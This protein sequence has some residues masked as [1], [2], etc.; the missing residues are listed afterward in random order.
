MKILQVPRE[1]FVYSPTALRT[2]I[3]WSYSTTLSVHMLLWCHFHFSSGFWLGGLVLVYE[4]L[5][6]ISPPLGLM[7]VWRCLHVW[8]DVDTVNASDLIFLFCFCLGWRYT[9]RTGINYFNYWIIILCVCV[10][11]KELERNLELSA[12]SFQRQLAAEK[13]RTLSAQE[14]IQSL[15]EELQR[16]TNRLK[17]R[18]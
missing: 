1:R 13:R 17:V 11:F 18:K 6:A 2:W 3:C 12:N 15:Q 16:V 10:C 7:C 4:T 5:Q 9:S 8:L 14:E